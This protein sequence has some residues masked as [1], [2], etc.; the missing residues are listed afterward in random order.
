M[1]SFLLYIKFLTSRRPC[2]IDIIENE[3]VVVNGIRVSPIWESK[4]LFNYVIVF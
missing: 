1:S 3:Q 4:W 2:L